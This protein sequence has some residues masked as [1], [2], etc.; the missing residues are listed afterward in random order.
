M[1]FCYLIF[2]L[3]VGWFIACRGFCVI[4]VF[5]LCLLC[6]LDLGFAFV[7]FLV[8]LYGIV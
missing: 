8:W 6:V 3:L 1:F 2:V 7:V 5:V 4:L